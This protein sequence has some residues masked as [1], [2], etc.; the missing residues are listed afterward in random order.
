MCAFW[1]HRDV[2]HSVASVLDGH[3]L[4]RLRSV[5]S[6][7]TSLKSASSV[8]FVAS[9][10]THLRHAHELMSTLEQIALAEALEELT[11]EIRFR[12]REV[13]LDG[14][15]HEPLGRL[16]EVLRRHP[17]IAVSIEGHCGLEAPRAM[18]FH[19]TRERANSVKEVLVEHGVDEARLAVRGFSNTR[20]LV[21]QLG[22]RAGAA[23]RRVEVYVKINDLEVPP[24][25]APE[26][27]AAP[28]STDAL[29]ST[30]VLLSATHVDGDEDE[31]ETD[32]LEEEE[33]EEEEVVVMQL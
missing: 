30:E 12:Y 6:F 9:M 13:T 31:E 11:T 23:N 8:R 7:C 18:G 27:Y 3:S 20:P 16:A 17:D 28:P 32:L 24:R 5:C 1:S 14:S 22:E 29:L 33:E 19:F 15:S 2:L 25:R 10:R 21:W 4:A 26:D